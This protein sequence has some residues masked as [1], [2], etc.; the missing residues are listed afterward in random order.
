MKIIEILRPRLRMTGGDRRIRQ[1]A[2]P[3]QKLKTVFSLCASLGL[4]YLF[5]RQASPRPCKT[6]SELIFCITLGLHYLC[7]TLQ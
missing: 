1:A 2:P 3:K 4:H 7:K 5:I 6:I